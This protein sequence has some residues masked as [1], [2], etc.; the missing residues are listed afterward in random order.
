M[1]DNENEMRRGMKIRD[2]TCTISIL[3]TAMTREVDQPWER[4]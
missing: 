1:A 3:G 2:G 4:G